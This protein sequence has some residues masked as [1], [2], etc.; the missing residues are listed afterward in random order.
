MIEINKEKLSKFINLKYVHICPFF[1][2]QSF[3]KVLRIH[4]RLAPHSPS[5]QVACRKWYGHPGHHTLH[6]WCTYIYIYMTSY[7][8]CCVFC[9]LYTTEGCSSVNIL[10]LGMSSQTFIPKIFWNTLKQLRL[11]ENRDPGKQDGNHEPE[12]IHV[13]GLRTQTSAIGKRTFFA[14]IVPSYRLSEGAW[15]TVHKDTNNQHNNITTST[16]KSQ[17]AQQH[18]QRNETTTKSPA[19]R[20]HQ[21]NKITSKT[22]SPAQRNH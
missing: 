11:S 7:L 4:R 14:C 5:I 13:L 8:A 10:P 21:R 12:C 2:D 20:N 17:P 6:I 3:K 18:H 9:P 19:Q 16:T 22:T 1:K 15:A